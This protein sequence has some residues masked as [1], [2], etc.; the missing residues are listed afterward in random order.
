MTQT[1]D[2]VLP[3]LYLPTSTPEFERGIW[4]AVIDQQRDWDETEQEY[5]RRNDGIRDSLADW[6]NFMQGG[7]WTDANLKFIT[8]Y[9]KEIE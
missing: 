9:L 6:A 3:I 8:P 5:L 1:T 7:L 2:D 4:G